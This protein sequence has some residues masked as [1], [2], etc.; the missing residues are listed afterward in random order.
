[1]PWHQASDTPPSARIASLTP[2]LQPTSRRVVEAILADRAAAVERTAQEL[3]EH[4]GVGRT[5]VVRT[6]Q[7]LGYEGFPQLRVALAQELALE[8][9]AADVGDGSGEPASLLGALRAGVTDFAARVPTSTSALTEESLTET[10]QALDQAERV[11]VAAHGLSNP[12]GVDLVQRLNSV[13]RPAEMQLDA[14]SQ[15]VAA[16]QLGPRSV[17]FAYSGSGANK[18]TLDTIRAAQLGGAT[19][20]AMTS[21][22]RSA[23]AEAADITLI[24]PP[25]GDSFQDELIR[26]SRAAL[27][28]VTEQLIDLLTAHRGERGREA[29]LTSLSLLGGSLQE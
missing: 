20:I 15:Q 3:A 14:M 2:S 13:G 8:T 18:A 6:A 17:C 24:V 27:M 16:R 19:V 1:M 22:A 21:F 7:A 29:R 12:L 23:V 25:T 28:L 26:T 11:L 4:V 10:I 5:T 9:P